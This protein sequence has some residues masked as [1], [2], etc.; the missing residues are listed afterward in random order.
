MN[1]SVGGQDRGQVFAE[2]IFNNS[3]SSLEVSW[4]VDEFHKP[5][6]FLIITQSVCAAAFKVSKRQI[7]RR[8]LIV[9]GAVKSGVRRHIDGV[10]LVGESVERR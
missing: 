7:V 2:D 9:E 5:L 8:Y 6:V 3:E 1:S 10:R 4:A